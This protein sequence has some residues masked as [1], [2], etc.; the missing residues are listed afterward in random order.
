[1]PDITPT[2]SDTRTPVP[3]PTNTPSSTITVTPTM[4]PSATSTAVIL[5]LATSRLNTLTEFVFVN[6][7]YT[8]DVLSYAGTYTKIIYGPYAAPTSEEYLPEFGA[9][10]SASLHDLINYFFYMPSKGLYTFSDLPYG[11]FDET[12]LQRVV[13]E[14]EQTCWFTPKDPHQIIKISFTPRMAEANLEGSMY[15]YVDVPD[16]IAVTVL[17]SPLATPTPTE[18]ATQTQ[19]PTNTST[20]TASST[21]T[22][23]ISFSPTQTCSDT[24]TP[25]TSRSE[26]PTPTQSPTISGSLTPT[27]TQTATFTPT[28]TQTPTPTITKSMTGTPTSTG[29]YTNTP[30]ETPTETS[31]ITMTPTETP[32][33]TSSSTELLIIGFNPTPTSTDTPTPT[34]TPTTTITSSETGTPTLTPTETPTTSDTPTTTSS[35]TLS[36]TPTR[37]N[38]PSPTTTHTM[39]LTA[40][41]TRTATQTPSNTPTMTLTATQTPTVSITA[42]KQTA[43]LTTRLSAF[44]AYED[45]NIL[46]C[47]PEWYANNERLAKFITPYIISGQYF[48][49]SSGMS[50][51]TL[52]EILARDEAL[53]PGLLHSTYGLHQSASLHDMIENNFYKPLIDR[54]ITYSFY[55][56]FN[57]YNPEIKSNVIVKK[58]S[59]VEP[60]FSVSELYDAVVLTFKV[61]KIKNGGMLD[62]VDNIAGDQLV[63]NTISLVKTEV[64]TVNNSTPTCTPTMT[65]TPSASS[66]LS[67][68]QRTLAYIQHRERFSVLICKNE[69]ASDNTDYIDFMSKDK[70]FFVIKDEYTAPENNVLA[71]YESLG[72]A[73]TAT[74]HDVINFNY[75]WPV[76]QNTVIYE[77]FNRVNFNV[78]ETLNYTVVK[79]QS[80]GNNEYFIVNPQYSAVLMT[81]TCIKDNVGDTVYNIIKNESVVV[82]SDIVTTPS[83]T[84]VLSP[85]PTK[86]SAPATPTPSSTI[87]VTPSGTTIEASPTPTPSGTVTPSSTITVTPSST[88]TVT[89]SSTITVTPTQS[90]V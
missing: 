72:L 60:Y 11:T 26:T 53:T 38:T 77:G 18:T 51:L 10:T 32:T 57:H 39:T 90:P 8:G 30:T 12:L 23:T 52:D 21:A 29:V 79:N 66:L 48:N 70:N 68:Y 58:L 2:P 5:E 9:Y 88:I 83:S 41:Q 62:V 73:Q 4:T 67:G 34:P 75:Y 56:D 44:D 19:T 31:Q 35:L 80:V 27:K 64:L 81:F 33:M 78:S 36:P 14:D 50:Q 85:T 47:T 13:S 86:T 20:V 24:P 25:T 55:S 84:P 82:I 3:T 28:R 1:M 87:T 40:T 49:V 42:T 76:M 15:P 54:E 17:L 71:I 37:T 89:P 63:Y 6:A 65:M 22:P 43:M 69:W 59:N 16:L 74:I 46:F 7:S 45:V 61:Y